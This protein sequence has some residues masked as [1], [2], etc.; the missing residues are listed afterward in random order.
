MNEANE[1]IE[2]TCEQLGLILLKWTIEASKDPFEGLDVGEMNEHERRKLRDEI[3]MLRMFAITYAVQQQVTDP[4]VRQI[5][6]DF[7]HGHVGES[8]EYAG[9]GVG[10][11]ESFEETL[12]DRYKT[13]YDALRKDSEARRTGGIPWYV[14]KTASEHALGH[15]KD[16]EWTMSLFAKFSS[17]FKATKGLLHAYKILPDKKNERKE[18]LK[19]LNAVIFA[20]GIKAR[21]G[22][23][24][25]RL[26]L[27]YEKQQKN[28]EEKINNGEFFHLLRRREQEKEDEI[29][30][31]WKISDEKFWDD[32]CPA[33]D[34]REYVLATSQLKV[35]GEETNAIFSFV[36]NKLCSILVAPWKRI[37]QPEVFVQGLEELISSLSETLRDP[38]VEKETA[39]NRVWDER[40]IYR[41][42]D[43]KRNSLQL[44]IYFKEQRPDGFEILLAS[45]EFRKGHI[46]R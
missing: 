18:P 8:M 15:S 44:E 22:M 20:F 46:D 37:V 3:V 32:S 26:R 43:I 36:D 31:L 5:I 11:R 25:G 39:E 4:D 24:P 34:S 19:D 40:N 13:Y 38:Y 23:S 12:Q 7:Y 30:P 28:F 29:A 27:F 16:P 1:R 10:E 9:V 35:L 14:G 33:S 21:L 45:E 2:V 17:T 42:E 41:W 6:L